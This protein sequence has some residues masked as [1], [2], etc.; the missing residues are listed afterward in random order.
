VAQ[1]TAGYQVLSTTSSINVSGYNRDEAP[2]KVLQTA[3]YWNTNVNLNFTNLLATE[4]LHY[5]VSLFFAEIQ[6]IAI[7][8]K[9]N[10]SMKAG[11]LNQ[12]GYL[13]VYNFVGL[14]TVVEYSWNNATLNFMDTLLLST[15]ADSRLGPMLNALAINRIYLPSQLRTNLGDGK[16]TFIRND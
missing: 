6:S 5:V 11:T 8:E 4:D 1:G 7:I 14:D 13:D 16:T 12:I 3:Q 15:T 2:T 9:R 10:I